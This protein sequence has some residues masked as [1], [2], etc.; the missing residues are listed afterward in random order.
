MTEHHGGIRYFG[1]CEA[2]LICQANPKEGKRGTRCDAAAHFERSGRH[3]CWV[4][5]NA[6]VNLE[7]VAEDGGPLP[8]VEVR[9]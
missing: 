4:H 7:F 2:L 1:P 5:K 6:L 9:T 3:V 8:D